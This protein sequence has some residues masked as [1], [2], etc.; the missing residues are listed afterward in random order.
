MLLTYPSKQC[1]HWTLPGILT[2]PDDNGNVQMGSSVRSNILEKFFYLGRNATKTFQDNNI[3]SIASFKIFCKLGGGHNGGV[4]KAQKIDGPDQGRFYALKASAA[5]KISIGILAKEFEVLA[6]FRNPF[7]VNM[8]YI[9]KDSNHAYAV[10]DLMTPF[11]PF[12]KAKRSLNNNEVAFYMA[13]LILAVQA[14]HAKGVVHKDIVLH[15]MLLNRDGHL[16]LADF[17]EAVDKEMCNSNGRCPKLWLIR[18][19][20]YISYRFDDFLKDDILAIGYVFVKLSNKYNWNGCTVKG[21]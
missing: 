13:E 7:I 1:K 15:N 14:L 11:R 18:Q 2:R 21:Y 6:K 17:G 3:T 19:P 10:M 5:K 20:P 12:L 16:V 9:F 8:T 4:Y